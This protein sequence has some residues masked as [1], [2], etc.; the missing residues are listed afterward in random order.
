V[1]VAG[2]VTI[3]ASKRGRRGVVD[4]SVEW[5]EGGTRNS[6]SGFRTLEDAMTFCPCSMDPDNV[7]REVVPGVSVT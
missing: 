3:R 4:Y 2:R 6:Q 5:L 1:L 7:E